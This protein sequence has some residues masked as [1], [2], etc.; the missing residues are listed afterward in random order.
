MLRP[1][2]NC[3]LTL[4]NVRLYEVSV[5]HVAPINVDL[6]LQLLPLLLLLSR[7]TR[8]NLDLSPFSNTSYNLKEL[9]RIPSRGAGPHVGVSL[10]L[11]SVSAVNLKA[12][13]GSQLF[14]SH[15]GT[16]QTRNAH[17]SDG[18][19]R[20][21]DRHQALPY[22]LDENILTLGL[23]MR[24]ALPLALRRSLIQ[25]GKLTHCQVGRPQAQPAY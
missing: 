19:C 2:H 25:T 9:A 7:F 18:I 14:I 12:S 3:G 10:W 24:G 16:R 23:V 21:K 22:V 13:F 1:T 15:L 6:L 20:Q 4:I 5:R 8:E 17:N 11:W